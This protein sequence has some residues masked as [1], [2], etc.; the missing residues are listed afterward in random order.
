MFYRAD[1]VLLS[2]TE[3]LIP[4]S[5]KHQSYSNKIIYREHTL[6][7]KPH[8]QYQKVSPTSTY[9]KVSLP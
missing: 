6:K 7:S 3:V 2:L 9:P 4:S 5:Y 8:I 1:K